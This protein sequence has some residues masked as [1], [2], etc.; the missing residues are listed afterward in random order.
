MNKHELI[1]QVAAATGLSRAQAGQAVNAAIEA[2]SG[3]LARDERV[4]LKGFGCFVPTTRPARP[5]RNPKTGEPAQIP[6]TRT[7]VFRAGSDLK[8][9]TEE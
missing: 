5:G 6:A 1:E 9:T 8:T 3:A 7:V 4:Q 2:M